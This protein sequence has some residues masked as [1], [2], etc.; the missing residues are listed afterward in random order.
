M[1]L[2]EGTKRAYAPSPRPSFDR[3]TAITRRDVTRHIWGDGTAGEVADFIYASTDKIHC[4]MFALPTGGKFTHSPEFRTVFGADEML[5]VLSGTMVI[6]NPETG[7]VHK[8]RQGASVSFGPD[9]WHHVFAHG[10]EPLR[11]LEFLCPPPSAGT[12]GSYARTRPY[13]DEVSYGRDDRLGVPGGPRDRPADTIRA[14]AETDIEWRRD[15]GV[16]TGVLTSTDNLTALTLEINPSEISRQH[17][18]G[19]DEL[20]FVT[21]GNLWVRVWHS[22]STYVFE[23][24]PEDACFIPA[25]AEH[26]YRNYSAD[27]AEAVIG[28]APRYLP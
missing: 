7:E 21:A 5:Y 23:L 6:A 25:G 18:H 20:L 19:G 10:G 27:V 11:I 3:P 13:L 26:E 4:L 1:T 16:L 24:G 9:T 15:L 12:T 17:V 2:I 28:V 22:D 14:I 8:V